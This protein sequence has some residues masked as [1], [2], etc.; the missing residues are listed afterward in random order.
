MGNKGGS[1][2]LK[3]KPAPKFWTIHRKEATWTIKP[4]PGPHPI[5]ESLPLALLIRDVLG[6]GKTKKEARSIISQGKIIVDGKVR[7]EEKF[8]IGLMDVVYVMDAENQYRV[9]P[10]EKG[11]IL[12]PIDK[13]ESSFKLCRIENKSVVPGGHVQLNLHDGRIILVKVKDPRNREEDVYQSMDV[14]KIDVPTEEIRGH[15]KLGENLTALIIAGKNRGKYGKVVA[16]EKEREQRRRK[17][18]VTIE[19]SHGNRF[20]TVLDYVF[21]LGETKPLIS[22]SEVD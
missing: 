19:D 10:S 6:L 16:I 7:K 21:T 3:R 15:V 11:L 8:P 13:E 4:V 2:H 14:L 5:I 20:Q 22:L 9:L 17:Q 1:R 12:H 18:L